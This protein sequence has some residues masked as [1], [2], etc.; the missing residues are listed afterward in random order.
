MYSTGACK[1]AMIV[2]AS[3]KRKRAEEKSATRGRDNSISPVYQLRTNRKAKT[4]RMK[5]ID[6]VVYQ[7][8][9]ENDK[10]CC[11]LQLRRGGEGHRHF[12]DFTLSHDAQGNGSIDRLTSQ[13][14]GE[15]AITQLF[16]VNS[17]DN[18]VLPQTCT[19]GR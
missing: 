9:C 14:R 17:E 3:R 19:V 4:K 18:I 11:L 10:E 7:V 13:Q 5:S 15:I 8:D 12:F 6:T 2:A 16:P 1:I